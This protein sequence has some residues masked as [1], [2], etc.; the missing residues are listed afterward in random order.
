MTKE[1][2]YC[3][4]YS[5]NSLD[6]KVTILRVKSSTRNLYTSNYVCHGMFLNRR[7]LAI[8]VVVVL[9]VGKDIFER[10]FVREIYHVPVKILPINRR[11]YNTWKHDFNTWYLC[12][13]KR[14]W[15]T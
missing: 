8:Y 14:V 11:R 6:S 9:Y 4:R 10:V 1:P 15:S 3:L 13:Y 5:K 12:K 2:L 7:A